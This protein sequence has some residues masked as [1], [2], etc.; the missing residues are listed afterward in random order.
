[1]ATLFDEFM[2]GRPEPEKVEVT[3]ADRIKKLKAENKAL[4][5][6]NK[7]LKAELTRA[8]ELM[9]KIKLN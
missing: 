3:D 5:A 6:E 4:K 2:K 7:A 1:M 9:K 8:E